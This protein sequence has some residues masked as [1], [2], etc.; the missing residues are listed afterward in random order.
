MLAF[1]YL[2]KCSLRLLEDGRLPPLGNLIMSTKEHHFSTQLK[3]LQVLSSK[4]VERT[5]HEATVPP[6]FNK[7]Y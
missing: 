7:T 4:D 3:T 1:D 5:N 6:T 2:E